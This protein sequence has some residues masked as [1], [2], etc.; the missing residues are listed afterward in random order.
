M[1]PWGAGHTHYSQG[2]YNEIVRG[3]QGANELLLGDDGNF[4]ILVVVP[5]IS[6][7]RDIMLSTS[8]IG[9][10][11]SADSPYTKSLSPFD[12]AEGK[13]LWQ[14]SLSLYALS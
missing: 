10:V 6:C 14:P 3:L 2:M 1:Q 9:T 12:P 11:L 7:F 8:S 13:A 5:Y 4:L